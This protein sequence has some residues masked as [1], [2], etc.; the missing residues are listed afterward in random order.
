[1]L[2]HR[3]LGAKL[4]SRLDETMNVT[5]KRNFSG[6][7]D[8]RQKRS[9]A[10][11]EISLRTKRARSSRSYYRYPWGSF[12]CKKMHDWFSHKRSVVKQT[13]LNFSGAS[14]IKSND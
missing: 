4:E 8:E 13:G 5:L 14:G 9:K 1:M 10:A 3:G 6:W 2:R 12:E 11:H 7:Q